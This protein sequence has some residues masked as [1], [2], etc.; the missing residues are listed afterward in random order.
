MPLVNIY[1]N[2]LLL[3]NNKEITAVA[4]KNTKSGIYKLGLFFKVIKELKALPI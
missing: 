2:P 3:K 4:I 1:F